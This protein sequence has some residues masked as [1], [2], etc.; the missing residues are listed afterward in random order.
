MAEHYEISSTVAAQIDKWI[1]KYPPDHKEAAV[2]AALIIV[3][4]DCGGWLPTPAMDAVADYL[5]MPKIAVYEVATFYS[6]YELEPV[7]RNKI[8]VCTNI[9]CGLCGAQ[10]V[11]DHLQKRLGVT[12][13]E[14]TEDN[15][16]TLKNAECLG[17]CS[18]APMMQV[19]ESYHEN[20]TPEKIDA[21][22]DGLE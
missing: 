7:G 6:M 22:L 20:L 15:R 11:V 10:K 1:E 18:G 5:E 19:N 9:S 16:I 13:G 2:M 21:I 12:L 17:A 8:W 14:T 3:Q 4:K